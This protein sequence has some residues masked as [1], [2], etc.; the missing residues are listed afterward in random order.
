MISSFVIRKNQQHFIRTLAEQDQNPCTEQDSCS[1]STR[2]DPCRIEG[3]NTD[4]KRCRAAVVEARPELSALLQSSQE[5]YRLCATWIGITETWGE[6][7]KGVAYLN[8]L[9]M[10]AVPKA[11]L[12]TNFTC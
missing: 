10:L 2:S 12:R 6:G 4:S 8:D 7:Q 5:L 3:E 9:K 11:L 1:G